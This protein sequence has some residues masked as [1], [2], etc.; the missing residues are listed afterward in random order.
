MKKLLSK[1]AAILLSLGLFACA[2]TKG[3]TASASE[4]QLETRSWLS[5]NCLITEENKPKTDKALSIGT[6]LAGVLIP[7]LI[8]YVIDK[9]ATEATKIK[10]LQS[11]SVVQFDLY[12]YDPALQR[13]P[14]VIDDWGCITTVTAKFDSKSEKSGLAKKP[15]E[16]ALALKLDSKTENLSDVIKDRLGKFDILLEGEVE[17]I[18]EAK[19]EKSGDQSAFRFS[20][21]FLHIGT[22]LGDRPKAGLVYTYELKGPGSK[23]D[24]SSYF[25]ASMNFGDVASG[26]TVSESEFKKGKESGWLSTIGM[27]RGSMRSFYLNKFGTNP[28]AAKYMPVKLVT[29]NVQTKKP[30]DAAKLFAAILGASKETI[31]AAL[32]ER[33]I[34]EDQFESKEDAKITLLTA[35]I[36][37]DAVDDMD[38]SGKELARLKY[39]KACRAF[40]GLGGQCTEK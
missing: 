29:T 35:E 24:G 37:Y 40:K 28:V 5:K 39:N 32:T 4:T 36:A 34:P 16:I 27:T 9:T 33:I 17:Q 26:T 2:S 7:K 38:T 14:E 25:M 1:C 30:S 10:K 12:S 31:S 13:H 20:S 3:G 11:G 18:Y 8:E 15:T 19:L 21:K 23:P 22:L 6:A